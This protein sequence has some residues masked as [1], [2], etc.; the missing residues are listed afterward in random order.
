M[1]YKHYEGNYYQMVCTTN[2]PETGEEIVI[3]KNA[4]EDYFAMLYSKFFEDI[5]VDGKT[6]P[7]FQK[8]L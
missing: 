8:V 6:V 4:D 5:I 1:L 2:N 7:R 3:Y